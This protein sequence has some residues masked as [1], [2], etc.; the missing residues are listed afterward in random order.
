[1]QCYVYVVL[2]KWA[3]ERKREQQFSTDPGHCNKL[4]V[5]KGE[6]FRTSICNYKITQS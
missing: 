1:M 2:E 3:S 6:K 4:D 5:Y